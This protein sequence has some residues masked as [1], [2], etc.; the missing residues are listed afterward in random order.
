MGIFHPGIRDAN[1]TI[2]SIRRIGD[3]V[4]A[5][6]DAVIEAIASD[7]SARQRGGER[8]QLRR[9]EKDRITGIPPAKPG[10]F[11]GG[12][13]IPQSFLL[14]RGALKPRGTDELTGRLQRSPSQT[15][16]NNPSFLFPGGWG[17]LSASRRRFMPLPAEHGGQPWALECRLCL[18]G[19]GLFCRC[20]R[21]HV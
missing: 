21:G 12:V 19:Y 4:P 15:E 9:H 17:G 18:W 2:P 8:R 14:L 13:V 1:R 5:P 16:T 6:A 10:K 3:C 20:L 11:R 7:R